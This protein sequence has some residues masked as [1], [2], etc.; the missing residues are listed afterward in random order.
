MTDRK[1]IEPVTIENAKFM[2]RPD[3]AGKRFGTRNVTVRLGDELASDLIA[4]GWNVR[5]TK[6][7]E[8]YPDEEY[9]I[10]VSIKYGY[11]RN[12]KY[13]HPDIYMICGDTMTL[14]DENTVN[15]LDT[16]NI[17]NVDLTFTPNFYEDKVTAYLSKMYVTIRQD[18]LDFKY[19][20]YNMKGVSANEEVYEV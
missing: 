12:G 18:N 4:E 5:T 8:D 2:Y 9:Y 15:E 10:Q 7:T 13:R 20:K 3:F 14:L 17:E 6:V 19:S 16:A 1:W 11:D